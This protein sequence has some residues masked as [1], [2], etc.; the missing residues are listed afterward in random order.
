VVSQVIVWDIVFL[1]SSLLCPGGNAVL[2]CLADGLGV[3][4]IGRRLQTSHTMVIKH[5]SKIASLLA[6]LERPSLLKD[7]LTPSNGAR[8]ASGSRTQTEAALRMVPGL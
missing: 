8:N 5:R 3:R 4:E 1:L 2:D 6:K 7:Q